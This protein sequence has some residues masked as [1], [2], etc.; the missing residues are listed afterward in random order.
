MNNQLAV[1]AS[2][3]YA[4]RVWDLA[5]GEVQLVLHGHTRPVTKLALLDQQ[6][7]VSVS[8]DLTMRLWDV[9][10][11]QPPLRTQSIH[12]DWVT[13]L[14]PLKDGRLLSA[15]ADHYLRIS[16]DGQVISSL[17]GHHDGV[18]AVVQIDN[19][20]VISAASDGTLRIW[21]VARAETVLVLKGHDDEVLSVAVVGDSYVLSGSLDGTVRL[22]DHKTGEQLAIT[23]SP[24]IMV[25][26]ALPDGRVFCGAEDGRLLLWQDGDFHGE[27]TAHKSAIRDM[28]LLT[29]DYMLTASSDRSVRL[30]HLE[31]GELVRTFTGHREW[32]NAIS[33]VDEQHFVSASFD[34]TLRLWNREESSWQALLKVGSPLLSLARLDHNRV[35]VGDVVGRLRVLRCSM[36]G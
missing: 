23:E 29:D 11:P 31:T 19:G 28:A 12:T 26:L 24:P 2:S 32:V 27:I 25:M 10:T 22:W 35:V 15:S 8:S 13:A 36:M 30:W 34:G 1:V 14:L 33:V 21:D 16:Q 6:H 5:T 3:D 17:A 18:N 20:L 7:V 9:V 4:L